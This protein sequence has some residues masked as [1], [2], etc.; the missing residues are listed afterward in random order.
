MHKKINII[1][2][3]I[4]IIIT[5]TFLTLLA[6]EI[7][8]RNF[9]KK[10]SNEIFHFDKSVLIWNEQIGAHAFKKPSDSIMTNGH[11]KEEIYIDKNGFRTN[12]HH[13]NITKP[14]IITI[15]DSQ[16]FGHGVSNTDSWP[17]LLSEKTNL[18]V[19]N[20]GVWGYGLANYEYLIKDLVKNYKPKYLIYGMTDNDICSPIK[21]SKSDKKYKKLLFNKKQSHFQYLIDKPKSYFI[22]FTSLGAITYEAYIKTFYGTSFGIKIRSLVKKNTSMSLK[23]KCTLPTIKWLKK[24]A[25]F[26]KKYDI[27]LIVI[28][29]PSPRRIISLS[30]GQSQKN[31][32]NSILLIKENQNEKLYFFLDPII[33]LS[34]QYKKNNFDRKSIILPVD[35]HYNKSTNDILANLLG[36]LIYKLD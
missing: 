28:S 7:F 5:S 27:K 29:L 32:E 15:G 19:G 34:D 22:N 13:E 23:E 4:V 16:T 30:K 33:E 2:K 8:S 20:L 14:I 1:L 35:S 18:T 26:L 6:L 24:K 12:S 11:F 3:N 10:V 31:Y 36:Q 9:I 21:M 25:L 17:N